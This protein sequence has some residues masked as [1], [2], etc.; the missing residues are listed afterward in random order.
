MD[1]PEP[2]GPLTKRAPFSQSRSASQWIAAVTFTVSKGMRAN[3][4]SS[5]RSVRGRRSAVNA[6]DMSSPSQS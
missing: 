6:A 2:A 5:A 4:A 1:F 3:A